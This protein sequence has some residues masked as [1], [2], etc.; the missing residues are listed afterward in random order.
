MPI[1]GTAEDIIAGLRTI[2][3]EIYEPYV[4]YFLMD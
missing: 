4:S 1:S 3:I 2:T